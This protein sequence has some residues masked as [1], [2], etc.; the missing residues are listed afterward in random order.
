MRSCLCPPGGGYL[1][2][3]RRSISGLR[4]SIIY[5]DMSCQIISLAD[6]EIAEKFGV[7]WSHFSPSPFW[8]TKW[9]YV[10]KVVLLNKV[11]DDLQYF[12]NSRHSFIVRSIVWAF[13]SE[14]CLIAAELFPFP[15]FW[16]G[17]CGLFC[18]I[19]NSV[20]YMPTPVAWPPNIFQIWLANYGSQFP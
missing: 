16:G 15:Y 6:C 20:C 9:L 14:K 19:D 8:K 4:P 7:F 11:W 1:A 10:F 5:F 18:R 13:R 3:T 2:F 12:S 17:R